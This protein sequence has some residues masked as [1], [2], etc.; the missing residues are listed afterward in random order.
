MV[1]KIG[2][3]I[4]SVAIVAA[5]ALAFMRLNYWERSAAVFRSGTDRILNERSM[6]GHGGFDGGADFRGR[7]GIDRQD[8]EGFN[9]L[10]VSPMPD[11]IR[12]RF[13]AIRGSREAGRRFN[14]DSL[15]RQYRQNDGE[16]FNRSSFEGRIPG[17]AG[18]G[19]GEVSD[20]R[21]INLRNIF[22]YLAVFASFTVV[23][24]YLN[25][26]C[27]LIFIRKRKD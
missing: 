23:A 12:Q 10:G 19:R 5:G 17:G 26:A 25:K 1:K 16:S 27:C 11:S 14:P 6:R 20:G 22:W 4:I 9:R 18:H 7:H 2:F 21:K 24:I 8:R 15:N 13:G 3:A